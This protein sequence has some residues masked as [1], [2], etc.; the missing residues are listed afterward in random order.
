MF[1]LKFCKRKGQDWFRSHSDGRVKLGPT[2]RSN[3]HTSTVL[4]LCFVCLAVVP[5]PAKAYVDPNATGLISQMLT[6]LLIMGAAGI[7][8]FRK[9]AAAT[10]SGLVRL[11]RRRADA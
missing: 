1:Q 9:R 7:T 6:P 11:L 5:M 10:L 8:F 3:S 4:F 2:S